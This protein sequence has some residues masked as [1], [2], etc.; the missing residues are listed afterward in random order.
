[1]AQIGRIESG[2]SS[3]FER[4][5]KKAPA[6]WQRPF[7]LFASS[8]CHRRVLDARTLTSTVA[9]QGQ[10]KLGTGIT[11]PTSSAIFPGTLASPSQ[12]TRSSFLLHP[13]RAGRTLNEWIVDN[14]IAGS[15]EETCAVRPPCVPP[16]GSA[17]SSFRLRKRIVVRH[18]DPVSHCGVTTVVSA[19]VPATRFPF[20]SMGS[21]AS[22]TT[23]LRESEGK[24]MSAL[25]CA[26]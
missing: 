12:A 6:S 9:M 19:P 21:F 24:L 22:L 1:M 7:L 8:L 16:G 5:S 26:G 2:V 17:L 18:V 3:R 13:A 20:P 4:T 11:I 23:G 25:F 14:P 15:F 10:W